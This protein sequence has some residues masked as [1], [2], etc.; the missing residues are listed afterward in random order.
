MASGILNRKIP[1]LDRA[2][3]DEYYKNDLESRI[4]ALEANT[5]IA[6]VYYGITDSLTLLHAPIETEMF[7]L[8]INGVAQES[9]V[10]YTRAGQNITF[11]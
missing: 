5:T 7:A 3:L 8:F 11:T 9:G 6:E 10:A 1:A 2:I 4:A